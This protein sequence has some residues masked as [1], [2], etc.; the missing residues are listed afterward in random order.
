MGYGEDCPVGRDLPRPGQKEQEDIIADYNRRLELLKE[1]LATQ[2]TDLSSQLEKGEEFESLTSEL[3]SWLE[4]AES[5]F[6]DFRIHDP[7]S[8]VIRSQQQECQVRTMTCVIQA[9]RGY[10]VFIQGVFS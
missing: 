10:A 6:K 4:E 2:F 9:Y 1:R 8:S 5:R 3:S 7:K